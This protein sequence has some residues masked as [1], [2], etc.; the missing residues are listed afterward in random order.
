MNAV[1]VLERMSVLCHGRVVYVNPNKNND[2]HNN[3]TT[4]KDERK[5]IIM[6]H[7]RTC[8]QVKGWG[9]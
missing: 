2:Q 8:K 7:Q 5:K 9:F 6:D 4:M 3:L 1:G